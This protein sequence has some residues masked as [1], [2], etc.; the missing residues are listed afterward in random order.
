[1]REDNFFFF[2]CSTYPLSHIF[3]SDPRLVLHS[4]WDIIFI[5]C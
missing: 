5:C 3:I 2:F 4:S 1:M